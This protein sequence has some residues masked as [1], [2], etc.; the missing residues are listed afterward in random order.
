MY[1]KIN[2]F[3][4]TPTFW[5]N[6]PP[7]LSGSKILK[8]T[9]EQMTNFDFAKYKIVDL[10]KSSAS[11][12]FPIRIDHQKIEVDDKIPY[13][14]MVHPHDFLKKW[15][16]P[17]IAKDQNILLIGEDGLDFTP[18]NY[19]NFLTLNQFTNVSILDG[20]VVKNFYSTALV[21]P[22]RIGRLLSATELQNLIKTKPRKLKLIDV[23]NPK[24]SSH[25]IGGAVPFYLNAFKKEKLSSCCQ[26]GPFL[27]FHSFGNA[28]RDFDQFA[29]E[30]L[31]SAVP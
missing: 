13:K 10:R 23:R 26:V 9:K 30:V 29:A 12:N 25:F 5:P 11:K 14:M 6:P 18:Y 21:L 1:L 8:L 19:A 28:F 15:K 22:N 4:T 7:V 17:D 31:I 3:E 2:N 16:I 24:T 27:L 20:G